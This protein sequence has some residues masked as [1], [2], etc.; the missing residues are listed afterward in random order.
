MPNKLQYIAK[1]HC[2]GLWN[3]CTTEKDMTQD[4][5]PNYCRLQDCKSPTFSQ[6]RCKKLHNKIFILRL[7]WQNKALIVHQ[8]SRTKLQYLFHFPPTS[9]L[10]IQAM[11]SVLNSSSHFTTPTTWTRQSWSLGK[12]AKFIYKLGS[13]SWC[14]GQWSLVSSTSA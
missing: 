2:A 5:R 6:F 8:N 12:C 9:I 10:R 7:Q 4:H 11:E 14:H 1:F 13:V 3:T